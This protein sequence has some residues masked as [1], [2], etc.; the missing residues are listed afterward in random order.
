MLSKMSVVCAAV[1]GLVSVA[2][3]APTATP[4]ADRLPAD[5]TVFYAEVDARAALTQVASGMAFVDPEI[6]ERI[7]YQVEQLYDLAIEAGE[8]YEFHPALLDEISGLRLFG[9]IML[10]DEPEEVASTRS[11]DVPKWGPD[12]EFTGMDVE[13]R[14]YTEVHRYTA[15]WVIQTS[16]EAV[17]ADFL[18][19][20]KALVARLQEQDPEGFEFDRQD[21]EVE[22]GELTGDGKGR[23][24]LGCLDEFV[25]LSNGN[26]RELWAALIAAPDDTVS[27]TPVVRGLMAADGSPP[28]AMV[29]ANL[30]TLLA[31][32]QAGLRQKMEESEAALGVE[33][34]ADAGDEENWEDMGREA[35]AA[36]AKAY[37]E[38]YQA[39][40]SIFS[41]G[42][43]RQAGLGFAADYS[44][45]TAHGV[46]RARLTHGDNPSPALLELM[47]GSGEFTVPPLGKAEGVLYMARGDLGR[48]YGEVVN[49]MAAANPDVAQQYQGS[50]GM[51][52]MMI[53]VNVQEIL[54]LLASDAYVSVDFAVEEHEVVVDYDYDEETGE[55]TP[56]TETVTGPVT[57]VTLLWG[58]KDPKAARNALNTVF[59]QLGA[60]PQF[61]QFARKRIYQEEDVYCVGTDVADEDSYPDGLTSF[62]LV[63]ADRYLTF[64]G[65][66]Y[67][68][69]VVRQVKAGRGEENPELRAIIDANPDANL[70]VVI[71][72]TFQQ[73][74]EEMGREEMEG[75]EAPDVYEGL[76]AQLRELDLAGAVDPEMADAVRSALLELVSSFE[77]LTEKAQAME[78]QTSVLTGTHHPGYYEWLIETE[79]HK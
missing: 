58:L 43:L 30:Q 6:A 55:V 9:V 42:E 3:A 15:S 56:R 18:D 54:D 29:T 79:A 52:K 50:Q 62:A 73:H 59:T 1:A 46:L 77:D 71:P 27:G 4:L 49:A 36:M 75:E 60:N 69:G 39:A 57:K 21:L 38:F 14:P 32:L 78:Q 8:N 65:W 40:D 35:E 22:R 13:E 67:V 11:V 70:I 37:Y 74:M 76:M 44:G 25:I 20:F 28:L 24:T 31:Q 63:V 48:V 12:G 23:M 41:L 19:Q 26:P 34:G 53:G 2:A 64:G 10:K 68:T 51:M 7:T 47:Q 33:G 72:K 5:K 66:D 45:D 61:A 17:A 16:R